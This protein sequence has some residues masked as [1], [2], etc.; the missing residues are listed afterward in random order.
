MGTDLVPATVPTLL[1]GEERNYYGLTAVSAL[2]LATYDEVT[3]LWTWSTWFS[4]PREQDFYPSGIVVSSTG[5]VYCSDYGSYPMKILRIDDSGSLTSLEGRRYDILCET[6][7]APTGITLS[8]DEQY[9]YACAG[10]QSHVARI[11][12]ATGVVEPWWGR[13]PRGYLWVEGRQV[14]DNYG[15]GYGYGFGAT[16]LLS[17]GDEGNGSGYT[18]VPATTIWGYEITPTCTVSSTTERANTGTSSI[19]MRSTAA[20]E[21]MF[22]ATKIYSFPSG[23]TSVNIKGRF[24]STHGQ[25]GYIYLEYYSNGSYMNTY[26]ERLFYPSTSGEW[27]NPSLDGPMPAGANGFRIVIYSYAVAV[28]DTLYSDDIVVTVDNELV[29]KFNTP[30]GIVNGGDGYIY[31][32]DLYTSTGIK[33]LDPVS[34]NVESFSGYDPTFIPYAA[35]TQHRDGPPEVARTLSNISITASDAELFFCSAEETVRSVDKSTGY[36]GSVLYAA[37]YVNQANNDVRYH[38]IDPLPAPVSTAYPFLSD[39]SSRWAFSPLYYPQGIACTPD[40]SIVFVTDYYHHTVFVMDRNGQVESII[41]DDEFDQYGGVNGIEYSAKISYPSMALAYLG[42][43]PYTIRVGPGVGTGGGS[44][45]RS[46][47]SADSPHTKVVRPI[48][49]KP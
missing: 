33:R 21:G 25:H 31:L 22:M 41:N 49:S 40:G 27:A 17:S 4:L 19:A 35:M 5:T 23:I 38:L 30:Q 32:V 47:T 11:T 14:Q 10:N 42:S 6:E 37:R 24:S 12:I 1:V 3:Q 45:P 34:R 39:I 7:F 46:T 28:G 29:Y 26:A 8:S 2:R 48:G 36:M 16:N 15:D 20:N 44:G 9:L 18:W 43:A 13:P